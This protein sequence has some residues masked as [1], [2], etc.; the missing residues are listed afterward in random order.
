MRRSKLSSLL[1][2]A[3][4]ISYIISSC[5]TS[6][7]NT[8]MTTAPTTTTPTATTP[9]TVTPP[10][11]TPT[12]MNPPTTTPTTKIQTPSS[13]SGSKIY[14]ANETFQAGDLEITCK[15]ALMTNYRKL[16][17]P[18]FEE[19]KYD[20]VI[21]G[22]YCYVT[23]EITNLSDEEA[24]MADQ[25]GLILENPVEN[26]KSIIKANLEDITGR[27]DE[28][29]YNYAYMA[30]SL[31]AQSLLLKPREKKMIQ[32]VF[33]SGVM[34]YPTLVG[35][36]KGSE[37]PIAMVEVMPMEGVHV[38]SGADT[39]SLMKINLF[40]KSEVHLL[41]TESYPKIGVDVYYAFE[42]IRPDGKKEYYLM[43]RVT[44]DLY[45]GKL[46]DGHVMPLEKIEKRNFD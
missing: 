12:T 37:D 24:D 9:T 14:P 30:E 13:Q 22:Y 23:F 2:S 27:K 41:E 35:F 16:G 18:G 32:A 4:L 42:V 33:E 8:P 31:Y 25:I 19:P 11:T 43:N 20:Q 1:I 46:E 29:I 44:E 21:N 36:F 6:S 34:Y 5:S 17:K 45:Q 15:S 26:T 10:T 39:T 3:I 40:P 7:P 28:D 38:F